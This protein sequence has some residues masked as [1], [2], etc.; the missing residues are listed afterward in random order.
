[1]G[2]RV[3]SGLP[4][5]AI[6]EGGLRAHKTATINGDILRVEHE[7]WAGCL[8][9]PFKVPGDVSADR[10]IIHRESATDRFERPISD[11]NPRARGFSAAN[12]QVADVR[13]SAGIVGTG[14]ERNDAVRVRLGKRQ[15]FRRRSGGLLVRPIVIGPGGC[16]GV[17]G[18]VGRRRMLHPSERRKTVPNR[19]VAKQQ[20]ARRK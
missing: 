16:D 12:R 4:R 2:N 11:D 20:T 14:I 17:L 1:M 3:R 13:N 5:A 7:Q 18:N 19:R 10:H 6:C 9:V 15:Q 8:A